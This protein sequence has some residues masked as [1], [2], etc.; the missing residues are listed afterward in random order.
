M[1]QGGFSLIKETTAVCLKYVRT[2][3]VTKYEF[4][5]VRIRGPL[6]PKR[7]LKSLRGMTQVLQS[8]GFH[9]STKLSLGV[10]PAHTNH[11]QRDGGLF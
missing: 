5:T 11:T 2:E 8:V 4:M 1:G 6:I 9:L 3:L 7:P 10:R